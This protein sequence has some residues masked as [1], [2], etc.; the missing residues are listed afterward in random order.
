MHADDVYHS[1]LRYRLGS[2]SEMGRYRCVEHQVLSWL[3]STA[4]S[5]GGRKM[6]HAVMR[7]GRSEPGG[8]GVGGGSLAVVC[9]LPGMLLTLS[10]TAL[11]TLA[12]P[13]SPLV[14]NGM[15]REDAGAIAGLFQPP[16]QV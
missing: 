2:V 15:C 3:C 8:V 7:S 12:D 14:D 4:A 16:P 1:K 11:Q 5:G 10:I 13:A 6:G 9:C